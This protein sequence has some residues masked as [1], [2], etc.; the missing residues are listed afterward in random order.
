LPLLASSASAFP[1][2]RKTALKTGGMR[3]KKKG[4]IDQGMIPR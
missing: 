1:E 3:K 2:R 4:A